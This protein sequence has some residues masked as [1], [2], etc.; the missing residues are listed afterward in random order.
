MA[1]GFLRFRRLLGIVIPV[2]L[3]G[4]GHPIIKTANQAFAQAGQASGQTKAQEGRSPATSPSEPANKKEVVFSRHDNVIPSVAFSPDGKRLASAGDNIA[5]VT[6]LE[7]GKEVLKL[8]NSRGMHFFSVAYSPDGR[9]LAAAQSQ[10]K[11][12]TS[13]RTGDTTITTLFYFGEVLVWDAQTGAIKA[14]LNDDN[15]PAWALAFSPDGK[16]LA[17]ATGP[18]PEEKDCANCPAFGEITLWD[19]ESWKPIRRLRGN[20]API[21]TLAFSP[22][23]QLIAGGASLMDGGRGVSVEEEFKFEIFLWDMTTGEQKQKLPGHTSVITS[24]AFSPDG[25]LLASAGRDHTLKIWDCHTYELKKTASDQMLSLE[26]MQTIAEATGAKSGKN[27]MPPVSWLNAIIFSRDGKHIIGGSGDSII[28]L[29]DSDSARII[30]V[31][32]PRGWPIF[33]DFTSPD[34]SLERSDRSPVINRPGTLRPRESARG[35]PT[36]AMMRGHWPSHPGSLNSLALSPDGKTLAL[37]NADGKL[38]LLT[39]K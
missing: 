6:D 12:K 16:W 35:I 24:L 22:D 17:V 38:R 28:R 39:L 4:S 26:E 20:S 21:R 33:S 7:T 25:S 10:L 13:Q 31:L 2:I 30:G 37:G 32:K 18:I 27:A 23:G 14:K 11:E 5:K 29:Y 15:D 19:T 8:K 3:A 1:F 34:D 36:R 9:M